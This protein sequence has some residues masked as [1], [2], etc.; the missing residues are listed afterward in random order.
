[1]DT[2]QINATYAGYNSLYRTKQNAASLTAEQQARLD[3]AN[4]VAA[5]KTFESQSWEAN[6]ANSVNDAAN[7]AQDLLADP[8]SGLKAIGTDLYTRYYGAEPGKAVP[9]AHASVA[10]IRANGAGQK[11]PEFSVDDDVLTMR[12]APKRD[13]AGQ[14]LP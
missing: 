1:M 10:R 5:L 11:Y 7:N 3:A 2:A 13:V 8:K 6:R 12:K 14:V 9:E 4:N